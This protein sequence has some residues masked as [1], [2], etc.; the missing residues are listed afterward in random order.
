M[1]YNL[2]NINQRFN[3]ELGDDRIVTMDT[4]SPIIDSLLKN[5]PVKAQKQI[6]ALMRSGDLAEQ[7]WAAVYSALRLTTKAIKGRGYHMYADTKKAWWG[8]Y[9]AQALE[10]LK[11][12]IAALENCAKHPENTPNLDCTDKSIVARKNF[13]RIIELLINNDPVA[14]RKQ[15]NIFMRSGNLPQKNWLAVHGVLLL[16]A[17]A[18]DGRGDFMYADT[19]KAWQE[20]YTAQAL[21]ELCAYLGLNEVVQFPVAA[22][23]T[24]DEAA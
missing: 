8:Y 21:D 16:V 2:I 11:T 3:L 5:D 9:T 12:H 17:K 23:K 7:D 18:I 20:Y 15:L 19:R 24:E 13:S 6:H 10:E 4:F 22:E 14:A 1:G